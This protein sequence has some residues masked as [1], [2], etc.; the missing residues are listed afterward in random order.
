M[1]TAALSGAAVLA[2]LRGNVPRL[3]THL[4]DEDRRATAAS[5]LEAVGPEAAMAAP[6]LAQLMLWAAPQICDDAP[7]F[8]R[9]FAAAARIGPGPGQ[10]REGWQADLAAGMGA[11]LNRLAPLCNLQA[12]TAMP[13]TPELQRTLEE[14][15]TNQA[16]SERSRSLA[17]QALQIMREKAH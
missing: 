3:V 1:V 10:S 7:L 12:V 6:R 4:D 16:R 13:L 2:L 5:M 14:L 11:V 15:A 9:V 8:P 17:A